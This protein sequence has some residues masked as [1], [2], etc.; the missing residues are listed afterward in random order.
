VGGELRDYQLKGV[1]WLA[2]LYENGLNGI[3]AD[4]MYNLFSILLVSASIQHCQ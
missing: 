2:S 1:E 3:L 4:E